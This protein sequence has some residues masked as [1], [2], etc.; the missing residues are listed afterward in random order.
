MMRL[1]L[2]ERPERVGEANVQYPYDKSRNN[3][4]RILPG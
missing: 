1:T 2:K 3:T 4:A